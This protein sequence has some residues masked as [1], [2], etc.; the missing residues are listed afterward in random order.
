[1]AFAAR[2]VIA[3]RPHHGVPHEGA[4]IMANAIAMR[5]T[6]PRNRS[7]KLILAL[8]IV[9]LIGGLAAGPAQADEDWH[10]RHDGR[11]AHERREHHWRDHGYAYYPA[12]PGYGYYAPPPVVYAPPPAV[13]ASPTLSFVFPLRIH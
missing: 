10:H 13:Y 9:S 4:G 2:S 12:Y 1:M 5:R 3:A 7:G 11:R 6:T 8:G